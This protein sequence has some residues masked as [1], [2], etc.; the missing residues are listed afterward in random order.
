MRLF[1]AVNPPAAAIDHLGAQ[2]TR[3]RVTAASAAGVNVRLAGPAQLH[4]TVSFLGDVE[5]ARLVEVESA[6]GS[7]AQHLHDGRHAVPRLSLGGGGRFG[8]GRSTVL[9]VGLRG[10]VEA[11]HVLAGLVRSRLRQAR[12]PYDAR[13]LR[14]HLTVA[15][16]ADRMDPADI[17][18]DRADLDDYRG[19]EWQVTELLLMRSQLDPRGSRYDRLAA[20]PL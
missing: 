16:P 4:V 1:V 17:E 15:R 13:P 6:L 5:A 10:E 8:Q 9:W 12:L 7:A 20:W 19:P 14:P 2:V 11:L 3:L 18:A